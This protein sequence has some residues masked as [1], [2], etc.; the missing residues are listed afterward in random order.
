MNQLI[1]HSSRSRYESFLKCPRLGYLQYHYGGRGIVKAGKNI[2]LATG[3]W[4][5]KGLELIGRYLKA[6]PT[7]RTVP[8]HVLGGIIEQVVKSYFDYVFPPEEI[9]N[10]L[11]EGFDLTGETIDEWNGERRQFTD[12]EKQKIQQYTFDEQSSLIEALL[13]VFALRVVPSWTSKYRI[14]TVENDMAFPLVSG[15]QFEVIQSATVDLVLQ[16]I[17]TKDLY[18][19]S[20]KGYRAYDNN[21]AKAA[22]H[23]TQGLSE[24]WAFDEYLKIKKIDKRIMGV[25][26]LYLIKGA[27]RETKRGSGIWEQQS[28]LLRGYRKLGFNGPEYAHSWYYPKPENDS[29]VG[30]LGKSWEKFDVFNGAGLE[31]VGGVKGWVEKLHGNWG[32]GHKVEFEVQPECGDI[33]EQLVVEPEPYLRHE[34]DIDSWLRQTKA[35]ELEIAFKLALE[36]KYIEHQAEGEYLDDCFPQNR[37]ACHY[38]PNDHNDCVYINICFGTEEERNNPLMN[39]FTWRKPHHKSEELYQ[40]NGQT[41]N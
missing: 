21:T 13:R 9:K 15:E 27:R 30:A 25:K 10:G 37:A 2:F 29:G 4:L 38:Y 34:R 41:R 22:S 18:L 36:G 28:S 6:N 16:E 19:V 14:V 40:I 20:Y 31:E 17:A 35:R 26:M 7:A 32:N 5:H 11:I 3:S 1:I 12:Y 23:D 39:G 33:L 8:E 24:S